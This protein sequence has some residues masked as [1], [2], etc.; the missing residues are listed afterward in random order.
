MHFHDGTPYRLAL[1]THAERAQPFY[2][3]VFGWTFEAAVDGT[4]AVSADGARLGTLEEARDPEGW[5]VFLKASGEDGEGGFE[6]MGPF[7]TPV[8]FQLETA[9]ASSVTQSYTE[10]F[11]L[12][13]EPLQGSDLIVLKAGGRPRYGVRDGERGWVVYFAVRDADA[14]VQAVEAHGGRVLE[15]PEDTPFGRLAVVQDPLGAIFAIV[16]VPGS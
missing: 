10:T 13:A 2:A 9:D 11:G 1:S 12:L 7:G 4:L 14:T 3:A 5:R 16:E 6:A 8:W 15:P